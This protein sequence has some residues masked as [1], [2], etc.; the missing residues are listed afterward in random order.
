M[1]TNSFVTTTNV[2]DPFPY[3]RVLALYRDSDSQALSRGNDLK[4]RI[5]EDDRYRAHWDSI[6]HLDLERE[7]AVA[8]AKELKA[9]QPDTSFCHQVAFYDWLLFDELAGPVLAEKEVANQPV[10][11]WHEHLSE[12]VY[13]RRMFFN[14]KSKLRCDENE[15]PRGEKLLCDWLLD[16]YYQ[17]AVRDITRRLQ[18]E[19]PLA[20][21]MIHAWQQEESSGFTPVAARLEESFVQSLQ[22]TSDPQEA[23]QQYDPLYYVA[24][25]EDDDL[26]PVVPSPLWFTHL[27]DPPEAITWSTNGESGP[28][29]I[30][31]G[32]AFEDAVVSTQVT[33]PILKLDDAIRDSLPRGVDI[34]WTVRRKSDADPSDL[35]RG[36]FVLSVPAKAAQVRQHLTTICGKRKPSFA[37]DLEIA[38]CLFD[39]RLYDALVNHAYDLAGVFDNGFP[40]L[41]VQRLLANGYRKIHDELSGYRNMETPEGQWA[42]AFSVESLTKG[43]ESLGL[44]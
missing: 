8:D 7:L 29:T 14:Y 22:K 24:A 19:M 30:E 43:Q 21:D 39:A 25:G 31:L 2:A 28:W 12:C 34:N 23:I 37:R 42:M 16:D 1:N 5:E 27:L 15:L 9:F 41:M 26:S 4:T 36:V 11:K 3:E 35:V 44:N 6:R 18:P 32:E 20:I 13:C 40:R 17:D 10:A 38:D 33:H